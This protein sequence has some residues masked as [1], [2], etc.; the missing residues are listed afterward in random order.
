MFGKAA[1][2]AVLLAPTA[3]MAKHDDHRTGANAIAGFKAATPQ[4]P[5]PPGRQGSPDFDRRSFCAAYV[6]SE[7]SWQWAVGAEIAKE[8]RPRAASLMPCQ[9]ARLLLAKVSGACPP[10]GFAGLGDSSASPHPAL[11]SGS[12]VA[13][14]LGALFVWSANHLSRSLRCRTQDR[15]CGRPGTSV[16]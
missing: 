12:A 15:S 4:H 9:F 10:E 6:G 1:I 5:K 16:S 3:S 7:P 8:G 14:T 11:C 2:M 13:P